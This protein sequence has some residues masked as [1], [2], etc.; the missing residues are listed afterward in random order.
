M[1]AA[2]NV[3][4]DPIELHKCAGGGQRAAVPPPSA[5]ATASIDLTGYWVSVTARIGV[6]MMTPEK[7]SYPS[8][9]LNE[10]GRRVANAWDPAKDEA[11]DS[12]FFITERVHFA[13]GVHRSLRPFPITRTCA[14]ASTVYRP[15]EGR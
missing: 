3:V 14:P 13:R 6:G 10:E 1:R 8:I 15:S 5:K 7:G 2:C 11:E 4:T 12:H 9:P